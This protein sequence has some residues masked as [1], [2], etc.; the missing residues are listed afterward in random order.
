LWAQWLP[1]TL[2]MI[3]RA[4]RSGRWSHGLWA[5]GLF[6]LQGLSCIYYTVFFAIVLVVVVP[7]LWT[8]A[9]RAARRRAALSLL[10]GMVLAASV[11]LPYAHQYQSS[12]S[13]VGDRD[14]GSVQVYSAGPVHYLAALPTSIVYGRLTGPLGRS[15][16]R[17]FPGFV[18][19]GL[20]AIALWPPIDRRRLA[21]AAALVL[22]IDGTFGH[23]GLL[24]PWLREH[25]E[26]FRGFRVP[27]RFGHLVL[28]AVS[29]LAGLGLARLRN[30]VR[31]RRPVLTGVV[32]AAIGVAVVVEYLMWPLEL[33]PVQTV[34][35]AVSLWLHSQP[36]AVVAELPLPATTAD[37]PAEARAAYRSTFYWRPIVNGYSGFYPSSYV[38]L[39]APLA[40]FPDANSLAALRHRGVTCLVV[41]QS[42]YGAARYGAIVRALA[43]RCDVAAAGPFPDG[44]SESRVYT[45]LPPGTGCAPPP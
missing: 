10:A 12:R 26:M 11:L 37:M 17:L 43:Q 5:G 30:V 31:V 16:K 21:Y 41:R 27:A 44:P 22:A 15:E 2:W 9:P 23:R 35:D 20:V 6:A 4:L 38:E 45:L 28:L 25:V 1:L 42:G 19:L 18:S 24:F 14:E 3:H 39:W 13:I 36:A 8:G 7:L 29:V 40:S 34:P 32:T 33:V